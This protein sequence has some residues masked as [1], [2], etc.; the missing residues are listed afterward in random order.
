MNPYGTFAMGLILGVCAGLIIA[1][2]CE[3][4]HRGEQEQD[5]RAAYYQG[6]KAERARRE[7]DLTDP[8]EKM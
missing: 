2:L 5:A 1:A 7:I 3:A 6:V 4:A 8:E